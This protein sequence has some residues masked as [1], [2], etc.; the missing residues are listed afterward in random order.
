M[1]PDIALQIVIACRQ[2][3]PNFLRHDEC[4]KGKQKQPRK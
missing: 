1:C 3:K 4:V 2:L